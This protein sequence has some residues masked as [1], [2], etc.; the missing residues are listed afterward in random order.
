MI[1]I[2]AL[3][4][5]RTAV[6]PGVFAF[7]LAGMLTLDPSHGA[8]ICVGP[9]AKSES[10]FEVIQQAAPPAVDDD[11]GYRY[12]PATS[13]VSLNISGLNSSKAQAIKKYWFHWANRCQPGIGRR[14]CGWN[15]KGNLV[16]PRLTIEAGGEIRTFFSSH[17]SANACTLAQAAH[18]LGADRATIEQYA[19]RGGV[20]L[21]RHGDSRTAAT[22]NRLIDVCI[23]ADEIL[24]KEITAIVLDYE[25][26]DNRTPQETEEFLLEYAK[27]VRGRNRQVMLYTN[28]LDAPTQKWTG[29]G[30]ANAPTLAKAFNAVG[31]TLWS[32]NR[33]GSIPASAG[34]QAKILGPDV[35]PSH[36]FAVFELNGT[37]ERDAGYVHD[38][39]KT[40][41]YRGLMIWRNGI[42]VR[43][44]CRPDVRRK[45]LCLIGKPCE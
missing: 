21:V 35:D 30:R 37:T 41:G 24:A 29:V 22:D 6:R 19:E 45:L 17:E 9:D 20:K 13:T 4:G 16:F 8:E 25:V 33:Q 26:Q 15:P 1:D 31:M 14:A 43:D 39:V 23:L 44:D 38:L 10:T 7:L 27:L 32:R 42:D 2:A 28:P 5:M 12:W 11:P 3:K 18:A 36:V 40:K 34:A